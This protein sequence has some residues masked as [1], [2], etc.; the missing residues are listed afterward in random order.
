MAATPGGGHGLRARMTVLVVTTALVATAAAGAVAWRTL[1]R[2]EFDL[3]TSRT[4]LA[5][6]VAAAIDGE[7]LRTLVRLQTVADIW[8]AS[9]EFGAEPADA[10]HRAILD[11][12]LA[13]AIAV[14]DSRGKVVARDG[15]CLPALDSPDALRLLNG[16]I[17]QNAPVV[18]DLV[19]VTWGCGE[20]A[21]AG[22]ALLVLVPVADWAGRS[23]G[24]VCSLARPGS[25]R[26]RTLME[27]LLGAE[28]A[29]A[30]L[31][32]GRGT[33]LAGD[34]ASASDAQAIVG[35]LS[36]GRSAWKVRLRRSSADKAAPD[37]WW[38]LV[39][40][41]PVTLSLGLLLAWGASRS[42]IRPLTTLTRA[43]DRITTGALDVPVPDLGRDE[44]G[45]L[46][47]AFDDMRRSLKASRDRLAAANEAL[48]ARVAERTRELEAA[49]RALA[50]RDKVRASLL[51]KVITA[52]EQERKRLARELHD[53]TCQTVTALGVRLEAV[54]TAMPPGP[55]HQEITRTRELAARSLDEL[56]RL[57][58]DLRPSVLDD[59]GLVAALRWYAERHLTARGVNVRFEVED[60][61][62]RLPA[63]VETAVFR[64]VQEVLSNVAR[65]AG[66][67]AVLVQ[68]A[69][70]ADRLVI[71]V[72]DDGVGFD[73]AEVKP[74]PGSAR[75]LGLLGLQERMDLVGGTVKV[76]S[77]PGR[78]T[79]VLIEVPL[80]R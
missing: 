13:D 22:V 37:A 42:V 26:F 39:W 25:H 4:D 41:F 57:I 40:A 46:G 50:D 63:E 53:E 5:Q 48:E 19:P 74:T 8:R 38:S 44:V 15:V 24:V 27:S 73:P 79:D 56:H 11:T 9:T 64:A 54:L 20:Q 76:D 78:G 55:I 77:T 67:D 10:L 51:R 6:S 32:D 33:R 18:S 12:P 62:P 45:R 58:H 36:A 30:A 23:T 1:A 29:R 21:S 60:D 7:V 43:A 61:G 70:T 65:H 31:V 28:I 72:E 47:R 71:Q 2:L 16:A 35:V 14:V 34:E 52:Q 69:R 68:F 80:A 17:G 59:L 3:A 49:N 66:A 75:G